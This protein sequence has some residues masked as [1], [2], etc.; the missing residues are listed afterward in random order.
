MGI[1]GLN[2]CIT[3]TTPESIK[4]VRWT[5]YEECCIGVDITCFL[6]RAL[7]SH[8]N[9]IDIIANQ[10][11]SFKKLKIKPIYVFDGKAPQEKDIVVTKRRNDRNDALELCR[12]LKESLALETDLATL[13][14]LKSKINEIEEKNPILTYEIK[15]EIKQ[16]LYVTGSTFVTASGEADSLLAY[17][18]KRNIIDAVISLDLD[19]VARGSVLLVPNHI[20]SCPGGPWSQYDAALICKGLRLSAEKF[21]DLC[22]LIGSDYTPDLT[23]VPWKTALFS[24]RAGDSIS[25]IW[26]RHTF[27]N[28][29]KSDS[30]VILL[31]DVDRLVKARDILLGLNDNP[32][33]LLDSSQWLK[34]LNNSFVETDGITILKKKYPQ[35]TNTMWDTIISV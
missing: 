18:F 23:I 30:N 4:S 25:E 32:E 33:T 22:V 6:Y 19:F 10:I 21:I 31:K 24:L 13:D 14:L 12:K 11:S 27:S 3:R 9:P 2:T 35:F 17:M 16:F 20:S 28:W 5:D 34:C 26:A 7:S 1:R 8:L 29:R 15:D